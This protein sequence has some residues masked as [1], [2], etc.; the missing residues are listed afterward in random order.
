MESNRIEYKKEL[1]DSLEKEVVAFLNYRDGGEIYIGIDDNGTAVGVTKSDQ[2]QL[3]IK[4]RIKNNIQPSALGLFDVILQVKDNKEIIKII[5]AAGLEKPYY[6][7]KYGMT[8]KGCFIRIGSSSEPLSQDMIDS[9]YSRRIRNTIGK[10]ESTRHNL[11]F[12]QLKIY[13]ETRKL[14]LNA[15]FMKN[16]ELLTPEEKPNYAAYLLADE[17]GVSIQ[18]AKYADTTR[19]NLI[20][21]IDFGRCSLIRAYKNVMDRMN[22]ENSLYPMFGDKALQDDSDE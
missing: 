1:T 16:L 15:A 7:R 21:N 13:Y 14:H 9:L 3:I 2:L 17:N 20:E 6:L 4:D 19:V 10:M 11:T 12:E 18:V 8:E 5:V 22:V